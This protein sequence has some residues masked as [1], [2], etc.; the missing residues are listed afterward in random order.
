MNWAAVKDVFTISC[1]VTGA[2]LGMFNT[3]SSLYQRRVRLR[4]VP[5]IAL[6]V[7]VL[8]DFGPEMGCL[9]VTNLS[10]FAVTVSDV[11]F[12]IDD[13]PRKISR[14]A[15]VQPIIHD[16]GT[17]PRRLEPRTSVSV[18]FN[19][20][21]INQRIKKAYAMTDCGAVAYGDSQSLKEIRERLLA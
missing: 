18:Y 16:G 20:N 15:I 11:G 12:T 21:A 19:P 6:P 17:W 10:A 5:K 9:E 4:V 1:A 3:W 7:T 14:A 13:D 2:A 8:G